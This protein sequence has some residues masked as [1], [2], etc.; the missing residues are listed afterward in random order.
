MILNDPIDTIAAPPCPR[1]ADSAQPVD[2]APDRTQLPQF[3]LTPAGSKLQ[4]EV[5][6]NI[7]SPVDA[8]DQIAAS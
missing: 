3:R 4:R 8:D 1:R 5:D 7:L 2:I 6:E